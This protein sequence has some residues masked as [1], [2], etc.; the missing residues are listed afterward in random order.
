MEFVIASWNGK[1]NAVH[2]LKD[3]MASARGRW[4]TFRQTSTIAQLF[5]TA[6]FTEYNTDIETGV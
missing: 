6:Y 2:L 5:N 4:V 3:N 1:I